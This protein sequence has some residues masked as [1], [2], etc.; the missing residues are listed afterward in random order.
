MTVATENILKQLLFLCLSY[1]L[2]PFIHSSFA[3][4]RAHLQA[5]LIM[6]VRGFWKT[7]TIYI[8]TAPRQQGNLLLLNLCCSYIAFL[9]LVCFF[10]I[11]CK[12]ILTRGLELKTEG[13]SLHFHDAPVQHLQPP[14][15]RNFYLLG[16][17]TD[18]IKDYIAIRDKMRP[19]AFTESHYSH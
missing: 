6:E 8:L 3:K 14:A 1:L 9:F 11:S 16:N 13:L 12:M 7:D 17:F 5:L 18:A 15:T 10:E 19:G 2:P 4:V